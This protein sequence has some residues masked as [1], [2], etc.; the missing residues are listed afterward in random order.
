MVQDRITPEKKLLDLIESPTGQ[1]FKEVKKRRGRISFVSPGALKGRFSFFRRFIANSLARHK[2]VLDI[3]EVNL[4]L[5]I[6]IIG[7][8]VYLSMS[9]T[10]TT[11]KLNQIPNLALELAPQ[12]DVNSFSAVS[13]LKEFSHYSQIVNSRNIFELDLQ[14][15]S[16]NEEQA[17][18][19][20]E[21]VITPKDELMKLIEYFVLV[22]V[23]WSDDPVAMIENT[24]AKMTYF[25]RKGDDIKDS[26]KVKTIFIDKV[27]LEY[28]GAELELKL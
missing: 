27:I 23:S 14:N 1:T 15:A 9:W 28:E 22:G 16:Q 2:I 25:V 26:I 6:C 18:A 19:I 20:E 12:K 8:V 7:F 10:D 4:I 21:K 24:D 17:D 13:L 11:G 3:K 5:T